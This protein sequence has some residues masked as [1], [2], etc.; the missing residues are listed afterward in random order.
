MYTETVLDHFINPRNAGQIE[1]AD[2]TCRIGSAACGDLVRLY[3]KVDPKTE[4]IEDIKFESYGCAANIAST[5]VTT[6]L[7]RGKSL[8][9]AKKV[10][11]KDVVEVLGG[12]PMHKVHC[13]QLATAGLKAAKMK[14]EAKTG[15]I[16]VDEGFVKRMLKGVLDPAEGVNVVATGRIRSIAVDGKKVEV[17]LTED[18]DEETAKVLAADVRAVLDDLG[19]EVTVG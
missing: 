3:L 9:E 5:S 11:F 2:V 8:D 17:L 1:N 7:A 4:R 18:V 12:L 19:L 16:E 15:K 10:R 13:A 6:E 14:Y